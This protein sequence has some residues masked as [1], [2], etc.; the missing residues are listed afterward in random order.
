MRLAKCVKYNTIKKIYWARLLRASVEEYLKY[1]F[2]K[3]YFKY[4]NSILYLYFKY[5]LTEVLQYLLFI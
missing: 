2:L 3:Y 5:F 1:K 4:M